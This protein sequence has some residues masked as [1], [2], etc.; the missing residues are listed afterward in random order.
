MSCSSTNIYSHIYLHLTR[1]SCR[2][3]IGFGWVMSTIDRKYNLIRSLERQHWDRRYWKRKGMA[4][5]E[6]TPTQCSIIS[7]WFINYPW[8]WSFY[9]TRH[10]NWQKETHTHIEWKATYHGKA[11]LSSF[12][13]MLTGMTHCR[14][15]SICAWTNLPDPHRHATAPPHIRV[16]CFGLFFYFFLGGKVKVGGCNVFSAAV[17][18]VSLTSQSWGSQREIKK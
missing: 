10:A 18:V 2:P 6:T 15:I 11:Y 17:V 5:N 13:V 12:C 14:F 9:L 1:P 4:I 3:L 8:R 16:F 7:I